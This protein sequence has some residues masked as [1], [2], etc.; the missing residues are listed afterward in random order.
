MTLIAM[1]AF[2][3]VAVVTSTSRAQDAKE[4]QQ[5]RHERSQRG[6][7][8]FP[9]EH[10]GLAEASEIVLRIGGGAAVAVDQATH[11][12]IVRSDPDNLD[13]IERL[14]EQIDKPKPVTTPAKPTFIQIRHR[15]IEEIVSLAKEN[16]RTRDV[17]IT[18]DATNQLMVVYGDPG[19]VAAVS[20]L[21]KQFDTPKVAVRMSFYFIRGEIGQVDEEDRKES[22]A[23]LPTSLQRVG[24]TLAENGF[25]NMDLLAPLT[26]TGQEGSDFS[27]SGRIS[28]DGR[29]QQFRIQGNVIRAATGATADIELRA[30]ISSHDSQDEELPT[31]FINPKAIFSMET[32]LVIGFGDDVILAAAP[33]VNQGEA[34]ALVVHVEEM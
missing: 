7:R 26:A 3:A 14:L 31:A 6:I 33:S 11:S 2:A 9:L 21:V 1:S 30:Q 16:L 17:R 8:V 24:A 23:A 28:V 5:A 12:L 34:I 10:A 32:R 20:E 15:D 22:I 27:T 4:P 18:A 25:A 29:T 19:D 13:K